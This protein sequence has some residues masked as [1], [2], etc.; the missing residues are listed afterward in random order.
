[1]LDVKLDEVVVKLLISFLSGSTTVVGAL[2][3]ITLKGKPMES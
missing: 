3:A 2:L 1:M